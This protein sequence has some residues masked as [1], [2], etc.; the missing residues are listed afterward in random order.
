[1]ETALIIVGMISCLLGG[2]ALMGLFV[3]LCMERKHD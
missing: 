3:L 1:M 2:G